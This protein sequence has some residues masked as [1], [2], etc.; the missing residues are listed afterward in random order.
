M[1]DQGEQKEENEE[2]A[3]FILVIKWIFQIFFWA[4]II[5]L[6]LSINSNLKSKDKDYIA[7]FI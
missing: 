1:F 7:I 5:Y 6:S 3:C 4:F 2:D